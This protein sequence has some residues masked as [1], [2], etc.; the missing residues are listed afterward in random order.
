MLIE[1]IRRKMIDLGLEGMLKS[2][3]DQMRLPN[4]RDLSFEERVGNLLDHEASFRED[5]RLRRLLKLA[6]LREQACLEDVDYS[7]SRGIDKS[8]IATLSGCNWI[9][10]GQNLLITGPTG[11]GKTW[12]ACAFGN[13]ACRRGYKT[14]FYRLPLLLEELAISHH[15][16]TFTKK[17]NQLSKL[18]LLILD[19]FGLS[20][21]SSQTRRDFLELVEARSGLRSTI[22]T[23]QL[24]VS[25]WHDF[26]S[27]GNST[28][29]DAILDRL[30]GNAHRLDL[31]GESLRQKALG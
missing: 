24:P 10:K 23:T 27:K 3:D 25:K 12:L 11:V 7:V 1:Q 9:G 18:D 4:F 6:K 26:L 19:D 8:Y 31:K 28:V 16:A 17:L 5:R 20:Q 22:V 2:F 21:L 13:Q 15:D 14:R 30:V 29:A